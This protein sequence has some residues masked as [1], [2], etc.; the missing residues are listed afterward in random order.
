MKVVFLGAT[1]FSEEMLKTLVENQIDIKAVFSI[2][3]NFEIKMKGDTTSQKFQNSNYSDIHSIATSHNISSYFVKGGQ[4]N[5]SSF[6]QVIAEIDPDVILVLGWYYIVPRKIRQLARL[7]TFGIHASLLPAYAGGSPLV[8]ALINGEEKTGLTMFKIEDGV[9]DGDILA[10]DEVAIDF[11]DDIKTLYDKVIDSAKVML[12]REMN[13]LRNNK[14]QFIVQDKTKIH[15]LP[16]RKPDDG[17]IDWNKSGLELYNFVRAQTKPYPCAFSF[18]EGRKIK[19]I[20]VLPVEASGAEKIV[21]GTAVFVEDN[22]L[23]RA[24]NSFI[25]PLKIEIDDQTYSFNE[26]FNDLKTTHIKFENN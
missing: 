8:W 2:P 9:D 19:F 21:P 15:P 6:E 25:K 20:S 14:A 23:I 3:Q 7:G 5:L 10:Q 26:Y 16:I 22:F 17:I 11:Q 12:V 4:E 18:H 1:K 13:N 24:G